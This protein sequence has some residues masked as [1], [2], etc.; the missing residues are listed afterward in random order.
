MGP[1]LE[2]ADLAEFMEAIGR[3]YW[4]ET[5][6]GYLTFLGEYEAAEK[7]LLGNYEARV[8]YGDAGLVLNHHI[9]PLIDL[10]QAW[11]KQDEAARYRAMLFNGT[12]DSTGSD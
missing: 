8:Y 2:I 5:Y 7:C 10:Y 11:G 12:V 3:P 1:L 9:R 4:S 6:G